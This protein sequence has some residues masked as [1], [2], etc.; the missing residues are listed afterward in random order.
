MRSGRGAANGFFQRFTRVLYV[1]P[2][3]F[4]D[5]RLV[6]TAACAFDLVPE[7]GKDLVNA[8]ITRGLG[9]PGS[10]TQIGLASP[11]N[12]GEAKSSR[13]PGIIVSC[14]TPIRRRKGCA[15]PLR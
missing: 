10:T 14:G 8:R 11:R 2:E 12:A 9:D 6:I 4:V 15:A 3:D 13:S 5:E 7:P 1:L